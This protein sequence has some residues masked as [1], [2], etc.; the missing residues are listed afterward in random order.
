MA[1]AQSPVYDEIYRF[2]VKSPTP[3]EII[4]FHASTATQER[5][6]HLLEVN[7]EGRLTED[8]QAELDKFESVNHFVSMLKAYA[9]QQLADRK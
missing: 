3:K 5:V 1:I 2:L 8:E 6:N 9:Y 4:A 7:R